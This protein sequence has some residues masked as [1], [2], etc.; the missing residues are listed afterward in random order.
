MVEKL[1]LIWIYLGNE[2]QRVA[3]FLH[4]QLHQSASTTRRGLGQILIQKDNFLRLLINSY[5]FVSHLLGKFS[6]IMA[7]V[8]GT[9]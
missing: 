1:R 7:F 2:A 5:H 4:I 9:N 6:S 8:C 3:N